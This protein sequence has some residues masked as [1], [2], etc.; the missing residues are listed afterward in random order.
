VL[1]RYLR[2]FPKEKI[3]VYVLSAEFGLL[4]AADLIPYYERRITKERAAELSSDVAR[5]VHLILRKQR[6]ESVGVSISKSYRQLLE[7]AFG[8][9][10]IRDLRVL[11]G[12]LGRRLTELRDWLEEDGIRRS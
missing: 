2:R 9:S 5:G 8:K 6:W 1:R 11:K 7:G 10:R 12:G 3:A 4:S